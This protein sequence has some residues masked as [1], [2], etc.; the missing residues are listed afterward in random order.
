TWHYADVDN[1][2]TDQMFAGNL[3]YNVLSS[4]PAAIMPHLF[5][6]FD[7][8]F[9]G[10]VEAGD[11]IIAGDNFGCGSSREH[12]AVGLAHAGIK[13]VIVKSV[14]RIF[15]RSSVN[16]GLPIIVLPEMV[17]AYRPGDEVNADLEKG[18]IRVNDQEFKFEPLPDKLMEILKFKGLVNWI[19]NN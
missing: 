6:G 13:A 15:Y 9:A 3:T 18:L 8:S 14:N 17:K 5:K 1:L 19:K 2:N 7:D 4:D 16:Q 10:K 11:I 12:P